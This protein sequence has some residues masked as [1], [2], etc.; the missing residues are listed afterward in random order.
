MFKSLRIVMLTC[1]VMLGVAIPAAAAD[2]IPINDLVEK[3]LQYDGQEVTVEGEA[4]GEVLERG[5]GAWININDGGNAIGIWMSL[6]D[7]ESIGYFGDYKSIGDT[8][9]VTGIFFRNCTAHGGDVDI[10][11]EKLAIAA[12]GHPVKETIS[13]AKAIVSG[14]LVIFAISAL[15]FFLRQRKKYAH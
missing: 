5:D 8:I 13:P 4:I 1:T 12:P 9:R 6:E 10:H 2:V 3:S 7:A 14:L 15:I 11:C